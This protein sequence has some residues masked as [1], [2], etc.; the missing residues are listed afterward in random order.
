MIHIATICGVGMGSS[1]VLRMWTE[2]VLKELGVEAK[3]EAMDASQG[4]MARVDLIL[5]SPALVDTVSGG[6]AVVKPI[7]NYID[8]ALI[9]EK[10]IEF[11][12]ENDI[13]YKP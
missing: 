4:K 10:L 3:V 7:H 8:K 5:T 1:L 6:Q 12:E 13:P 9:K 11:F 2:D